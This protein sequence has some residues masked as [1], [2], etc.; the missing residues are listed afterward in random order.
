MYKLIVRFTRNSL[1]LFFYYFGTVCFFV[2]SF[3]ETTEPL[4]EEEEHSS[5]AAVE[6]KEEEEEEE[7]AEVLDRP[8]HDLPNSACL[9]ELRET[10]ANTN[11]GTLEDDFGSNETDEHLVLIESKDYD[12]SFI[13]DE[14]DDGKISSDG[15]DNISIPC[16]S[17]EQ[18][19]IDEVVHLPN[20]TQKHK[21]SKDTSRENTSS[22]CAPDITN[23]P[24]ELDLDEASRAVIDRFNQ[25]LELSNNQFS[26]TIHLPSTNSIKK[27]KPLGSPSSKIALESL[28]PILIKDLKVAKVHRGSVLYC[29]IITRIMRFTSAMMIV[30]DES[31]V[32]DLAFYGEIDDDE[33]YLGRYLAI[34]EPF[35]KMR[36]DGSEGIRVD[37]LNDLVFDPPSPQIFTQHDDTQNGNNVDD[38]QLTAR[39]DSTLVAEEMN[40]HSGF[41]QVHQF[42][43][44]S[45]RHLVENV[46]V[47]VEAR[48]RELLCGN[49]KLG[50]EK[51]YKQLVHEGF[52]IKKKRLRILK[53]QVLS[54]EDDSLKPKKQSKAKN[55]I[56]SRQ[57][58]E[59]RI[60]KSPIVEKYFK[61]GGE[62]LEKKQYCAAIAFFT[63]ALKYKDDETFGPNEMD[64]YLSK[65]YY[66]RCTAYHDAGFFHEALQD[67]L[68]IYISDQAHWTYPII[69]HVNSLDSLGFHKDA[70]ELWNEAKSYYPFPDPDGL[71]LF[72]AVT[73]ILNTHPV[74]KV[75]KDKEFK[76]IIDALN[77]APYRSEILVDPGVYRESIIIRKPV[78]LHCDA[79]ND[80]SVSDFIENDG[81]SHQ[82]EPWA[83]IRS[84]LTISVCL[85][86]GEGARLIG[87]K[88]CGEGPLSKSIVAVNAISGTFVIR[89]CVL[90]S[91][92]GPVVCSARSQAN[93]IMQSCAIHDGS[94]GGLLATD[95][96]RIS[97]QNI[98]C[99]N[100]AAAGLEL[101]KGG[102][103]TVDDSHFY[104]NGLQGI[105]SWM[106]AGELKVANCKIYSH[107]HES[108]ILV[109]EGNI[110]VKDCE[111]FNN[112][113]AGISAQQGSILDMKRCCVH[114]NIEGILIQNTAIASIRK[115]LSCSNNAN[116]IFVGYD[117]TGTATLIDNVVENNNSCGI[118]VGSNR[119][120][121]SR[122][123]KENK[124]LGF[125]PPPPQVD[126]ILMTKKEL[127]SYRKGVK[128]N[129]RKGGMSESQFH[130]LFRNNEI[131]RTPSGLDILNHEIC[132]YCLR[133]ETKETPLKKC[134]RCRRVYY[135][136]EECIRKAWPK[137]KIICTKIITTAAEYPHF[138]DINKSL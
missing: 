18:N 117:H 51:M 133:P 28:S 63:E 85:P 16:N 136:S 52:K 70:L 42:Y 13:A 121:E 111:I 93:V 54:E 39:D 123:N 60:L 34:K 95:G 73:F 5:S 116:G 49:S 105:S 83:E 32:K 91:N 64:I 89:N 98:Y 94:Q 114:D 134:S 22:F 59:L 56:L 20:E 61:M 137:H 47:D 2:S 115:C 46:L 40:L 109:E 68:E 71:I 58:D 35:C 17:V 55:F 131:L 66:L 102:N 87:F 12:S 124:N 67:S 103:G 43:E 75:G 99:Y 129:W 65:L 19:D 38:T 130:D 80:N 23:S 53:R 84:Q 96:G 135:C 30:Q 37:D 128:K 104:E 108:G 118:L 21:S 106:K 125:P 76:S 24:I 110:E 79:V 8:G 112:V 132:G 48:V 122:G 25:A 72:N 90:T 27:Q 11:H 14:D 4:L 57:K 6:Q 100:N 50:I 82:I 77:Q 44:K 41:P 74:L 138:L 7:E 1:A 119:N 127:S 15:A 62:A 26:A 36:A 92:S 81:H 88:V 101:R 113:G 107:Y 9:V 31:G 10:E 120:V 3:L 97:L 33:L 86:K 69:A 45:D 78:T 29:R 126:K